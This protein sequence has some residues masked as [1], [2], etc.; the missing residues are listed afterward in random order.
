MRIIKKYKNR[1]MYDTEA[2][3]PVTLRQIAQMLRN[4]IK[5]KILDNTS[6]KDITSMTILQVLLDIERS[7][8]GITHLIPEVISW[9]A[10][11]TKQEFR[12]ILNDIMNGNNPDVDFGYAWAKRLIQDVID[13][14]LSEE[15][16]TILIEQIV[17]R[18][19]EFYDATY[20]AIEN[21]IDEILHSSARLALSHGNALVKGIVQKKST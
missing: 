1:I 13:P 19:N 16:E 4:N 3:R 17:S 15:K 18:L 8:K 20:M 21:K 9:V 10:K 5:I 2:S 6:G 14:N 12:K 7:E 11:T